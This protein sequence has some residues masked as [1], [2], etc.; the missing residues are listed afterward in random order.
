MKSSLILAIVTAVGAALAAAQSS[1]APAGTLLVLS[2][3]DLTLSVVDPSTLKVLG[4]VPSGPDPHEVI[5]SS[6]G[7]MAYIANYNGGGNIITPVD[8]AGMKALTPI[9]LG[10]LRA[11]HGLT[12]ADGKLWFTAEGRQGDRELRPRREKGGLDSR[13]RAEPHAHDL[14]VAGSVA[15]RHLER[16]LRDDDHH[17]EGGRRRSR[18]RR[19]RLS[20]TGTR[21]SCLSVVARRALTSRPAARRSGRLTRRTGQSRSSTSRQKE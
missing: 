10:P 12:F 1:S 7:R 6:D 20:P 3:G 2:K 21:P 5:A 9:D 13:H 18:A 8:L 14:R 11:P 15:D 16:Q 19:A 17:R 4:K